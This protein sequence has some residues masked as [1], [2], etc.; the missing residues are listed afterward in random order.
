MSR[1]ILVVLGHPCSD[2]LCAGLATAY[3]DAARA[4]GAQV[5]LLRL[6]QL[7]FDPLLHAGYREVQ[8]LEPDLLA[9][10]QDILWAQHLV[11]VYPIWWGAMPA[12]LK[13]FIDRVFLPG[14]AFKYREG[15]PL[16][17]KLLTGRTAE[18]LVT[19]DSPP[20]YYRWVTRMPGHQQMKRAILE[21]SGIRPVRVH[22][23]GPVR[24]AS[25]ERLAQ[26]VNAARQ[27]GNRQARR[28]P[29]DRSARPVVSPSATASA[30]T[31]P[32][33]PT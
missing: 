21:Y 5:R 7:T 27:L 24:S 17:D 14:F 22:S 2:S 8:A 3:A 10:Q 13:G 26:W 12:L 19:M 23:F 31:T 32:S 1:Q 18:L 28:G 6:G 29:P 4:A 33:T 9:A 20:W 25:T 15:S 30:T 11:W 16:W